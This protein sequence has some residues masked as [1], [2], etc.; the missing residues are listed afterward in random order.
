MSM[1]IAELHT[2][3]GSLLPCAVFISMP[4]FIYY[5]FSRS[6]MGE[7][8]CGTAMLLGGTGIYL[9]GI[10][11]KTKEPYFQILALCGLVSIMIGPPILGYFFGKLQQKSLETEQIE[12]CY[13][14]IRM[15]PN[16]HLAAWRL[17]TLL[18]SGGDKPTAIAIG[19]DALQRLPTGPFVTEQRE[20][21]YWMRQVD[22]T[23]IVDIQCAAC[24]RV[25]HPNAL[26]CPHCLGS[27]HLDRARKSSIS[28]NHPLQQ[29][30]VCWAA[31]LLILFIIPALG[32]FPPAVA[33]PG[34]ILMLSL[35][36][37]AVVKAFVTR[38]PGSA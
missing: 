17:A 12:I 37:W 18:W 11:W 20:L 30:L 23:T 27:V 31:L 19:Q 21:Q 34:I 6:I 7:M 32:N 24:N 1:L 2:S 36:S 10:M 15:N 22:L 9:I 35:A 8:G 14:Q 16:N 3:A 5:L 38:F 4:F 28:Q 29:I 26:I 13:Q 33:I 25:I